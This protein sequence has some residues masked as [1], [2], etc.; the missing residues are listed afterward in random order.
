MYRPRRMR[1]DPPHRH[2]GRRSLGSPLL[3]MLFF[4]AATLYQELLLRLF[5]QDVSFFDMALL[6]L[7]FFS[8]AAGLCLFLILDLL[9]WRRAARI[10]GGVVIVAWTVLLCVERGSRMSIFR[11]YV[12]LGFVGDMAGDVVGD[13]G[14]F[15]IQVVLGL[16]PFILLSLVPLAAYIPLRHTI[17]R[18]EGQEPV[19]RIVLAGGLVMFQLLGWALSAFGGVSGYYTYDYTANVGIPHFG[20]VTSVRLELE[21]A[22]LGAPTPPIGNFLEDPV[23]TLPPTPGGSDPTGPSADPSAGFSEEL[24]PE[25]TPT[26]IPSGPNILDIDFTALAEAETDE[27]LKGMHQYFATL[28]P[29]EKNQYTG[30]FEGKNLI[31][32]TAEAFSPYVISEELTPTLYRLTHEGFVF[33]NYYQPDWC[34]STCG[35]EFANT[36]G[37]I[38]NLID[39]G[40]T[41]RTAKK[42]YMPFT[43]ASQFAAIG[44]SVPAWHNH[45]YDYY[46]RNEYLTAFGYDYKGI[47]NGLEYPEELIRQW[48]KSDLILMENTVDSYID[49]YVNNGQPFHAYYMTV[50]GHA[51]Y[52]FAGGNAMST[53]NREAAQAAYPDASAT[54]QAYIACNLELEHAL[55][56]LVDK[57]EAA[58]IAG[59]TLIVMGADHYPY[60]MLTDDADYYNELRGFED[61]EKVTSRYRNALIMWSAAIEEPIVVDTPCYSCDIVPTLCNLFGLEYDSRLY[62]GRDIFATNYEANQYSNCMPLVVFANNK[63][64]GNSWITAAGTYEASTGTFTPFEG[65]VLEDQAD[66]VARVKRLVAAKLNYSKLIVQKNYYQVLLQNGVIQ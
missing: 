62:S 53:K 39:G 65:V 16:I 10:A 29:S 5:D 34:Q 33:T 13:F 26:P 17:L 9:P 12:G 51:N 37:V 64:Q 40:L 47:G 8:L 35:G 60:A 66:Y 48:P 58:G 25:P 59:D 28:V 23:Y 24:P 6:R 31:L 54:V 22:L 15:V 56:Y 3:S 4:P 19:A 49:G 46:S 57:L 50:S 45:T 27:T 41:T 36:T 18:E 52:N 61:T 43:L 55:T 30:M 20:L 14:S 1:K 11:Q 42:N 63:G 7:V 38:P 2:T 32:I 21:Y 44:Y